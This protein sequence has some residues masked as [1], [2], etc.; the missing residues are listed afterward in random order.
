M[1]INLREVFVR[2]LVNEY[3]D[4]GEGGVVGY[5]GKLD[6]R[7]P[8]QREFIYRDKQRDAVIDTINNSFPLNV[9]YWALRKDGTYEVIDGQ[10]R[11]I[12]I[13]QYV[14]GEFSFDNLYFHNLPGDK[15]DNIFNYRLMVYI[16]DGADS[17]KLKWFETINIAGEK[18][19]KQ[20]LRNAVY[21]GPW[22][23]DAKK[24]FSRTG[25]PAY[26]ISKDYMKGKPIR[27]DYLETAIHW[28]S[29]GDIEEYMAKQ[30]HRSIAV[31]LWEYFQSVINWV[32]KTFT[33]K[34]NWPLMKGVD[35]GSLYN[36]Y[37]DTTL[38]PQDIEAEIERLIMDDDITKKVGIYPY[39]LT[40]DESYLNIRTFTPEIKLKIYKKQA[41]KCPTCGDEFDFDEMEGDHIIP[42]KDG[43]KTN[44]KNCQMLCR[45]CNRKKSSK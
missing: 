13:A 42:W 45:N 24:Y 22:V 9:M 32:E 36:T 27:Q 3:H 15:R 6:I 31:E 11:T 16:C 30:Q 17:E 29:E 7:P 28:I 43:G 41:G 33:V 2:E 37:R 14:Q 23:S 4:D 10:Q 12:S 20:E 25:C 34:S 35:W 18:L 8:Y 26:Q 40:R 38:N 44:E 19:T 1:N 21:A 39:V 5:G